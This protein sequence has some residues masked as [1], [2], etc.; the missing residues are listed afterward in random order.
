[1]KILEQL[2]KDLKKA[3]MLYAKTGYKE[4]DKL[5]D[6]IEKEIK[7]ELANLHR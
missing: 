1:M 7:N 4:Y 6:K 5:V 2:K 3:K